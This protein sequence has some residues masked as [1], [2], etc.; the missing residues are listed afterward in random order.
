MQHLHVYDDNKGIIYFA[1]GGQVPFDPKPYSS[2][3]QAQDA[4]ETWAKSQGLI[5]E[6]DEVVMFVA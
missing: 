4:A 2:A 3:Y 5:G 6:N 1:T